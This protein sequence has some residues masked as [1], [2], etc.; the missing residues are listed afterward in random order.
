MEVSIGGTIRDVVLIAVLSGA[1]AVATF[2]L[3]R[4][5]HNP[6]V[7]LTELLKAVQASAYWFVIIGLLAA[8]LALIYALIRC[9]DK[10]PPCPF[11]P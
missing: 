2:M 5:L 8:I 9:Y 3:W 7:A 10:L 4:Y 6:T 11:C 1:F